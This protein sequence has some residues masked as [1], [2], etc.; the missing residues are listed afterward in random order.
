MYLNDW[1][2]G[3][4]PG[5]EGRRENIENRSPIVSSRAYCFCSLTARAD[6][7]AQEFGLPVN[8]PPPPPPVPF[9]PQRT[10]NKSTSA[11]V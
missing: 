8:Y 3:G 9:L 2:G 5:R 1:R 10:K 7:T 6:R 11:G 4:E